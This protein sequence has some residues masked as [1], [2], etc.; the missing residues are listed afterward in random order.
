[1]RSRRCPAQLVYNRAHCR[2]QKCQNIEKLGPATTRK[3]GSEYNSI[4][5]RTQIPKQIR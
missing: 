4:K 2:R 3:A 1:M 5:T